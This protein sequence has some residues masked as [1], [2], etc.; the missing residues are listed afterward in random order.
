MLD[1]REKLVV[2]VGAGP[3]GLRKVAGL[4]EAHARVLLVAPDV[5]AESLP[6]SVELR[7]EPY[8]P[9]MLAGATMVFACT[10]QPQLNARIA[11]DAR[12]AGALINVADVP[13]ECDF[14]AASVMRDGDVLLAIGSGGTSPG[15]AAWLRRRISQHLPRQVGEFASVLQGLRAIVRAALPED[16]DERMRVMS[17]LVSDETYDEFLAEGPQAVRNKLS[18]LIE[19][20]EN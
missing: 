4:R 2:V 14:Y 15:L 18:R 19:G 6:D 1:L 13:N 9:E 5:R 10:D 11:D 17:L 3:V 8:S 12:R 16:S 20:R 7:R